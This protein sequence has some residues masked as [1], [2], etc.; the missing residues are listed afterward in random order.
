MEIGTPRNRRHLLLILMPACCFWWMREHGIAPL[1]WKLMSPFI[2]QAL[3][4]YIIQAINVHYIIQDN[5]MYLMSFKLV[6]RV[7]GLCDRYQLLL[8]AVDG[9]VGQS[10]L[11]RQVMGLPEMDTEIMAEDYSK[12]H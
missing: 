8:E 10:M 5:E 7:I 3:A 1:I 11:I 6:I 4:P 12:L 9:I 2:I